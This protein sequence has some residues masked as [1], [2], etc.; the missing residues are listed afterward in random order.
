MRGGKFIATFRPAPHWSEAIRRND[1][2]RCAWCRVWIIGSGPFAGEWACMP[3]GAPL[4]TRL[5]W[6]PESELVER[7]MTTRDIASF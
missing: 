5:A 4:G 2:L 6:A 1:G 3:I 7:G